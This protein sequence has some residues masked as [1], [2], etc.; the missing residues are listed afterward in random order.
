M[1]AT[2]PLSS[3]L[4]LVALS[5][6]LGACGDSEGTTPSK[7]PDLGLYAAG[8]GGPDPEALEEALR[9]RCVS[10]VVPP[11]TTAQPQ[12]GDAGAAGQGSNP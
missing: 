9:E 2:P 3:C 11:S 7:C 10:P 8:D 6:L 5:L 4:T 1:S 12:G